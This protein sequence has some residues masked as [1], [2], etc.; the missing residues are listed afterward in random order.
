MLGGGFTR[1]LLI[2]FKWTIVAVLFID[3]TN[4]R[5]IMSKFAKFNMPSQEEQEAKKALWEDR[6]LGKTIIDERDAAPPAEQPAEQEADPDASQD[7]HPWLVEVEG[8]QHVRASRI[9]GS[10]RVLWPGRPV[11]RDLRPDRLNICHNN[12]L[13][14]TSVGF[15]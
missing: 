1:S 3:A 5:L 2:A 4:S 15:Y 13:I 9:P 11:T 7:E 12:E 14:I 6:L 8:A 10:V